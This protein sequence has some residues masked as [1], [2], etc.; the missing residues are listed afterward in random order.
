MRTTWVK[1]IPEHFLPAS[2]LMIAAP[3][4]AR[5]R[6]LPIGHLPW[7]PLIHKGHAAS[8]VSITHEATRNPKLNPNCQQSCPRR[9]LTP[10]WVRLNSDPLFVP[11]APC[12]RTRVTTLSAAITWSS[13]TTLSSG[14]PMS[15]LAQLRW[16]RGR[17]SIRPLT[18]KSGAD[19]SDR[20][21][22][23]S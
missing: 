22:S 23:A 19:Q 16:G 3:P 4:H 5:F 7:K 18:C 13:M 9:S 6:T 10:S 2:P 8:A 20:H 21:R 11:F 17:L 1:A 15:R 12:Q 14:K